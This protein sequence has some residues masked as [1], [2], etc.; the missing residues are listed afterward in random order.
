MVWAILLKLRDFWEDGGSILYSLRQFEKQS[1]GD[2]FTLFVVEFVHDEERRNI[3]KIII[4]SV[5]LQK[6]NLILAGKIPK[7]PNQM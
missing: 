5:S 2:R 6:C 1:E 4:R 7:F 3:T